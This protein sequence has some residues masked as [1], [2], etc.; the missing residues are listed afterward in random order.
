MVNA[1]SKGQRGEREAI[2]WL[3]PIV[4]EVMGEGVISLER[5]LDQWRAGGFDV[6]GLEWMALEIK[7]RES[8]NLN[9]WWV[10]TVKQAGTDQVPVL[11]HRRNH[12]PW[13]ARVLAPVVTGQWQCPPLVL[14]MEADQFETWLRY[15]I[16]WH[17]ENTP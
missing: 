9:Q 10:Q 14:D 3:Q 1:R 13:R 2:K 16:W 11:L 15:M 6:V 7:R 5:N 4:D 17:K 12:Q 8:F